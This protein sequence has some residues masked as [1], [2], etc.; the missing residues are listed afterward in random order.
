MKLSRATLLALIVAL[1]VCGW[2][3]MPL[4]AVPAS[5][6][7]IVN[8]QANA[9]TVGRYEKFELTFDIL[10]TLATNLQFPYDSNPP[11]G[12]PAGGGITV[13]G[14]FSNDGWATTIVQ[15]GFLYQG[16]TRH[17]YGELEHLYPEGEP[18]WK[19]RFAP[20]QTGEWRYRIR[21]TDAGGTTYYPATG[22]LSFTAVSSSN[23]G[24]LQVSETDPRYFE[25]SDHTPFIGVGHGS[26]V[27]FRARTYDADAQFA[28]YQAE[29]ANFFRIWL[30]G[31]S[32][33]GSAWAPWSSHHLSYGGYL[34]PTSLSVEEAY[35][36]GDFSMKLWAENP[37]MFQGYTAEIPVLPSTT[38]RVRARVKAVGITGPAIA[39]Q[40]YGFAIKLGEW[41]GEAC[42]APGQGQLITPYLTGNQ[43]WQIV[44]GTITTGPQQ[45]FLGD[46][47]LSL[48]NASGGAAYIDAVWVQEDL[49]GGTLG[50]NLVRKPSMNYHLYFDQS[51]SWQWDYILDQAAQHDVYLKLVILE[52]EDWT[53][54]HIDGNGNPIQQGNAGNFYAAPNTKVR[55]LHEAFWR[56]LI[57]RW[58]YA[59]SVHSWEL[60]N[61]GDPYS[62]AHYALA[63]ALGQYMDDHDPNRHM[64]TT[65]LWHSLPAAEFWGN[66]AYAA[67]DYADLHAY[68]STGWGL[69]EF[70]GNGPASPLAFE[71]Q[72]VYVR[73]GSGHSLRVPGGTS[74]Y[75][76][77]ITPRGFSI[78]G[79]GEWIVRY[80][81]KTE[82]WTGECPYGA[83]NTMSGPRLMWALDDGLGGNVIPSV[84]TGQSYVCSAPGG[85]HAW[86]Q[87]SSHKT[88]DGQT[89]P[90]KA[91]IILTDDAIHT[92]YLAVNNDFGTG[93]W[94]WID[95]ISI[96]RPDGREMYMN[97]GL[98]L[99]RMD[100]DAALYTKAYS[101][102]DGHWRSGIG[103]PLVRGEA[104]LDSYLGQTGEL[105]EVAADTEG[106]WFHN[107]IW[108]QINPGGMYDLYW[109]TDNI[110]NHG[111]HHHIKPFRDFMDGVPL[112]NGNYEDAAA[113]TSHPDLRAW[114]QKD[115]VNG[116]AHLWIQNRNHTWKNAIEGVPVPAL[117]GT[118]SIPGLPSGL[119]TVEWWDTY[120]GEVIKSE[121]LRAAPDLVLTL[122]M[123]LSSDVGVKVSW[124][125]SPLAPSTKTVVGPVTG[126]RAGDVLT[127][128]ITLV[129]NGFEIKSV[130]MMDVIPVHTSYIVGSAS[131]SPQ[132]GT[133]TDAG[134]IRWVG[135]LPGGEQVR[136]TFAV[137]IAPD[138]RETFVLS[139]VAVIESGLDHIE[140]QAWTVINAYQV[141]LPVVLK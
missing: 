126:A 67:V 9:P 49:G 6:P 140:R 18:A 74:F 23:R 64:V 50:P 54:T 118:V 80:W 15:P 16:Y 122:P 39:G 24:F 58:G 21:A 123:A 94:A 117:S 61:E 13:D 57:A 138:F 133:L 136:I 102:I 70:W 4:R 82:R 108:G 111:L 76:A 41:L 29:R 32:I 30:S 20:Q 128:T 55:W 141:F 129:N 35:G 3:G 48:V 127:Y 96:T 63:N 45:H 11:S 105:P 69:Y 1:V 107:F 137:Q 99:Q 85:T 109:Y 116:S 22:D 89:A 36:D 86:Q 81:V 34:P 93:G 91:R 84:S 38:Y 75:N 68:V 10:N 125:D 33:T 130:T 19:V 31:S 7:A 87:F 40:P 92:L 110:W 71:D 100:Y 114:G 135:T 120:T 43:G 46:F 72:A 77:T 47:Y 124:V 37:C 59:V 17:Q 131:T 121:T 60:V 8:V 52:K 115:V 53:Y 51:A 65:S 79:K 25:F 112:N 5:G 95:D 106:V 44:E 26:D 101:V 134:N 62:D 104:G 98:D 73:G 42:S 90:Q 27:D 2:S 12:V 56:Y 103:K 78:R 88:V 119:Y 66:P 113:Q 14:L 83:P 97:G 132:V 28:I 139:N